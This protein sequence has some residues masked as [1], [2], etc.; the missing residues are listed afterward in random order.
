MWITL[1]ATRLV[2]MVIARIGLA[3]PPTNKPPPP[4]PRCPVLLAGVTGCRLAW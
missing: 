1:I 3:T 4:P 2:V